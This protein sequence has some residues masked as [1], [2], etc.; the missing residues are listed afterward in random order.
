MAVVDHDT[1]F[2][3]GFIYSDDDVRYMASLHKDRVRACLFGIS[4]DYLICPYT[5]SLANYFVRG[6]VVQPRIK[7]IGA[8]GST[9]DELQHML[10]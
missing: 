3:L 2:G 9:V 8:K 5:F 1:P 7:K 10:H 4:F 6:L